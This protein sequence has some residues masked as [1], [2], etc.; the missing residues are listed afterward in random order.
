MAAVRS[1][2]RLKQRRLFRRLL[3]QKL[4]LPRL[5]RL[6]FRYVRSLCLRPG[7]AP[8]TR[9]R[10]RLRRLQLPL[11]TLTRLARESSAA[12]PSLTAVHRADRAASRLVLKVALAASRIKVLPDNSPAVLVPSI[13]RVPALPVPAQEAPAV[14]VDL[15]VAQG[16]ALVLASVLLAPAVLEPAQVDHRLQ[17]RLRARRVPRDRRVAVAVSSIPRPKKAR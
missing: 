17:A 4:L 6:W 7:H 5:L 16:L 12:S 14:Q 1:A 13:P 11:P 15:V 2:L 10:H 8:S 3:P 9:H